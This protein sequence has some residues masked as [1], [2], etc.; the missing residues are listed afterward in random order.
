V[1][2]KSHHVLEARLHLWVSIVKLS[3]LRMAHAKFLD[4]FVCSNSMFTTA[5]KLQQINKQK[6]A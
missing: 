5:L 6:N 1:R 3:Q 2:V 4:R